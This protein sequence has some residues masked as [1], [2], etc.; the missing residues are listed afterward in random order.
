[1]FLRDVL[2]GFKRFLRTFEE[3][4]REFL[5][6]FEGRFKDD[7]KKVPDVTLIG[8]IS[9]PESGSTTIALNSPKLP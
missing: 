6:R 8:C 3:G 9:A 5:R 7:S 4:I 1:M 2:K